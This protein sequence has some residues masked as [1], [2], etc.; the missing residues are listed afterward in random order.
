M[1]SFIFF[2]SFQDYSLIV[3]KK[4]LDARR[5]TLNAIITTP[6]AP[7]GRHLVP[8]PSAVA[9][10]ARQHHLPLLELDSLDQLPQV[11]RP[12]L[13]I[14][15]GYGKLIPESWLHFAKTM[16]INMHPSLLPNYRGRFPAEW[17][18]LNGETQTGVTLI[19]MTP[20]FDRGPILAQAPLPIMDTDTKDTLYTKLFTLGADL[21]IKT[22][23]ALPDLPVMS[24]P[25]GNYFYAR[26]LTR[27]DG[28]LPWPE[29]NS[30]LAVSARSMSEVPLG[31]NLQ[32]DR[33]FRALMPWPG[34][35]TTLP[36]GKRL[37]LVQLKPEILVQLEG[38]TPTP[39]Q[40]LPST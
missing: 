6:P 11:D 22:L 1:P 7:A 27:A 32:L 30:Q 29:F 36:S 21:L 18:I 2:G 16:A 28:F 3:L 10:Y 15:A 35:W 25:T 37:K 31:D 26:K 20:Q 12:D 39:W 40:L 8:T 24:Q 13:I 9:T 4:L 5:Y 23:P 17:A 14:V 33:K 38:K 34:L 19:K